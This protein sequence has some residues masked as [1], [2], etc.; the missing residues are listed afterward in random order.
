MRYFYFI[1]FIIRYG[2][3][4]GLDLGICCGYCV[5]L[6]FGLVD[7]GC[8]LL[9]FIIW[10]KNECFI[11]YNVNRREIISFGYSCK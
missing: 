4:L 11:S 2:D 10:F 7:G 3:F 6:V 1:F 5:C 8:W 9:W